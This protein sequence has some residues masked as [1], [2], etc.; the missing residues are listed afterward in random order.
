MEETSIRKTSHR[1][2]KDPYFEDFLFNTDLLTTKEGNSTLYKQYELYVTLMDKVYERRDNANAFYL[3]VNSLLITGL[4]AL[5]TALLN[6]QNNHMLIVVMASAGL[7]ICWSWRRTILTSKRLIG[8]KYKIIHLL[9]TKL[10][11][12]LFDTEWEMLS[13]PEHRYTPFSRIEQT[14]IY[15]FMAAYVAVAIFSIV[16]LILQ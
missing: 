10:P 15:A 4:T 9:E 3:S 11:A 8:R 12:R 1:E 16:D 2:E 5:L 13:Q 14:I 7:L 6:I